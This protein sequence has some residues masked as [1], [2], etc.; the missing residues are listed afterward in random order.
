MT[1]LTVFFPTADLA[2][3]RRFYTEAL[4]LPLRQAGEGQFIVDTGRGCLGFVA[5]GDGRPLAQGAC[6]SFDCADRAAVDAAYARLQAAG[7]ETLGT[8]PAHHPRFPVYSFFL[9]DPN[10]YTLEFQKV[11][12]E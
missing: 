3:C 5:Y 1:G 9:R 2:A 11:D 12:G 10:G 7:V 4:G 8:P 6:L